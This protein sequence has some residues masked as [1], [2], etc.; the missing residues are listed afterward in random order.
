MT[1]VMQAM[2]P[3][4]PGTV[5][6]DKIAEACNNKI[7]AEEAKQVA[8]K[9]KKRTC[10]KLGQD[11]HA[12]C[13]EEIQKHRDANPE[14]GDPPIEGEKAY[15][16]P[17]FDSNGDPVQP[18]NTATVAISR[19]QAI[20]NAINSL[21][22]GADAAAKSAAIGRALAGLVF[23]DA[24]VLG[25]PPPPQSKTF[26]DF[27]FACPASH[28]SKRKSTQANY[29]PP[30]QSPGQEAAHNALGQA[31]GGQTTATILF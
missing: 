24:A 5:V 31:T 2:G 3:T 18:V 12:C 25:P 1:I 7:N 26:V 22:A 17:R 14:N 21:P 4:M 30:S 13:E 16:R 8:N 28:R 20:T 23:P 10:Q 11:K 15:N 6:L 9:K 29:R 27:K 19:G